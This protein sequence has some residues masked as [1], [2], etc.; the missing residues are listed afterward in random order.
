[1]TTPETSPATAK[2]GMPPW[3]KKAIGIAVMAVVLVL[4]FFIL[5]ATV[6]RGWANF[7]RSLVGGSYSSGLAWGLMFGV[8]CTLVPLLLFRAVWQVRKFKYARPVQIGLVIAGVVVAVPNLL[9]LAIATGNYLS[10]EQGRMQ[11]ATDA[12]GFRGATLTG[13]IVGAVLFV[14]FLVLGY[15]YK[16]RGKD[17]DKMRGE[18]KQHEPQSKGEAP[19]PEI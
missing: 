19:A 2:P 5:R 3:A 14:G 15:M 11:F 10:A 4:T 7:V 18:L 8:L 12:P 16:K 1:M 9:T 13:A 6:P 17:L